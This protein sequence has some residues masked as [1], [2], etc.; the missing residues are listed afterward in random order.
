MVGGYINEETGSVHCERHRQEGRPWQYIDTAFI[1][2][3]QAEMRETLAGTLRPS[4]LGDL[5]EAEYLEAHTRIICDVCFRP[6]DEY[7][8]E[9]VIPARQL[10]GTAENYPSVS[11]DSQ[12][13]TEGPL[14]R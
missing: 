8:R 5:T 2:D 13:G 10:C 1:R 12:S 11:H 4:D 3:W 7:K 6:L 14:V 9:V